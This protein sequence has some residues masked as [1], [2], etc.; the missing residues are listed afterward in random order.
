M[1]VER[2]YD[3]YGRPTFDWDKGHEP[4][5]PRGDRELARREA[6]RQRE[7]EMLR[8]EEA[9]EMPWSFLEGDAPPPSM[10]GSP[11][12]R[13]PFEMTDGSRG[14]LFYRPGDDGLTAKQRAYLSKFGKFLEDPRTKRH[15]TLRE[16]A[17]SQAGPSYSSR[18]I[19]PQGP[20]ARAPQ[21]PAP[22][23][24]PQAPAPAPEGGRDPQ[25]GDEAYGLGDEWGMSPTEGLCLL[26]EPE[27]GLEV[28]EPELGLEVP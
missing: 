14:T 7:L 16:L 17:G 2:M 8:R 20:A 4:L 15:A 25:W 13:K 19:E 6:E 26:L 1:P 11:L 18:L 21:A 23:P 24:A 22:A 5:T 12:T 9:G 28:P 27:L 3:R 10:S